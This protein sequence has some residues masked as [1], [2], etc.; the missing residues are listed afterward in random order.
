MTRAQRLRDGIDNNDHGVSGLF[1]S[2]LVGLATHRNPTRPASW[3]M[4]DIGNILLCSLAILTS[5]GSN[6]EDL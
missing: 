5:N 4:A 2:Y 6:L 1:K 3:N